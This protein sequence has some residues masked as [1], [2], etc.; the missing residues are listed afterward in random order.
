MSLQVHPALSI[1]SENYRKPEGSIRRDRA[2][3]GDDFADSPLG[4]PHGLGELVLGDTHGLQEILQEDF[5]G[6]YWR[7][8]PFHGS[9]PSMVIDN[10]DI[11][12]VPF[13]P[14]ETDTPL[15]IDADAPLSFSVP[16]QFLQPVG[17]WDTEEIKAGSAVN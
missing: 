7:Y 16:S 2:L 9:S 11:V 6:M 14:P 3:S 4:H 10:L 13:I 15:I 8:L 5:T 12:C 17:R 1:R